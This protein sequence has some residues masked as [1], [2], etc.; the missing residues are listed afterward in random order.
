[1]KL[2]DRLQQLS[3][4]Y[5]VA[6]GV[7]LGF[8][9][10]FGTLAY[11]AVTNVQRASDAALQE[12]LLLA[13][14]T[15]SM[16]DSLLRHAQRQL[17]RL[18]SLQGH[19]VTDY[20]ETLKHEL[21]EDFHVI[22]TYTAIALVD[23]GGQVMAS[24]ASETPVTLSRLPDHPVFRKALETGRTA[25]GSSDMGITAH[26]PVAFVVV[27][28]PGQ[29]APGPL[30]LV[31]EVHLAHTDIDLVPL[32]TR[33]KT[34]ATEI[35]DARGRVVASTAGSELATVSHHFELVAPLM[36]ARQAGVRV[37][38]ERDEA[39]HIVAYAPLTALPDDG[40]VI[41]EEVE[42]LALAVP[43]DLR[44]DLIIFGVGA[45]AL[46]SAGAWLHARSVVRPLVAL[47]SLTGRIAAGALDKPVRV[48][49]GDEIGMLAR[50]F[51]AMRVQLKEAQEARLRWEREL[52]ERVRERTRE[53]QWLLGKTISAQ[54]EERQRI[55]RE[56]HD[57]AAQSMATLLVTLQ[58]MRNALPP[59]L[60]R[61]RGVM[62]Q[63]IAQ[64]TQALTDMRRMI[65]DLRPSALDDLGFVPALHAYA[66]ERLEATGTQ[67][68]LEVTGPEQRL[69]GPTETALFRILQE[70][71]NNVAKHAQARNVTLRLAFGDATLVAQV[72]DD[73]RGFDVSARGAAGV[74]GGVGLQSMRERAA[75]IG[76]DLFIES[77]PGRGT[78]VRVE[79]PVSRG[80]AHG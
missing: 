11:F 37:H 49:R 30:F 59:D 29:Y 36:A 18:A 69:P 76:G 5:Q 65:A 4:R 56:L 35:V 68:H 47:A 45:L 9:L 74:Q 39:S 63:A 66:Q 33:S 55:A 46:V 8:L 26:P 14:T 42:D 62:D 22:G 38:E 20:L 43:H 17:E 28:V 51:E 54:E 23:A 78:R 27:P 16:V 1:M 57:S 13:E 10:L 52:E 31:G 12:R 25:M 71:I 58:A 44:R 48:A 61:E 50:S 67:V 70:A 64:G 75:L 79:A 60:A 40:G 41:V 73:G 24:Q 6:V 3:L 15:A 32:P 53:C 7:A 77:T 21:Q 2:L 19:T 80:D 34:F 72:E